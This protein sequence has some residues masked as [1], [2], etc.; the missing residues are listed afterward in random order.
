MM[1]TAVNDISSN[2]ATNI[3]QQ[4]DLKRQEARKKSTFTKARRAMLILLDEDI[5]NRSEIRSQQQKV[6]DE[7]HGDTDRHV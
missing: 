4:I 6:E 2:V 7:F 3:K 5:P 1:K